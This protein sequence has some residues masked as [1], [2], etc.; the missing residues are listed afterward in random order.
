MLTRLN[1]EELVAFNPL[2]LEHTPATR[3]AY[4][5]FKSALANYNVKYDNPG[6]KEDKLTEE[7]NLRNARTARDSIRKLISDKSNTN[8]TLREEDC[9]QKI[10]NETSLVTEVQNKITEH[11]PKILP[12]QENEK[13]E[14]AT[15]NEELSKVDDDKPR[16]DN[17]V[18][19]KSENV[20]EDTAKNSKPAGT[21]NAAFVNDELGDIGVKGSRR[22]KKKFS[23]LINKGPKKC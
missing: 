15:L 14:T 11:K 3:R 8:E 6:H 12:G 19:E 13:K 9:T 20:K 7:R 16:V 21:S 17:T 18:V 1:S 4:A 22:N 10:N 23:L 5:M 2:L